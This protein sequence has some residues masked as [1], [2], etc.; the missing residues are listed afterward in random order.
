MNAVVMQDLV[1]LAAQSAVRLKE[2]QQTLTVA[3]SSAGGLISAALLAV[4]GAS[5]YYLGGTVV[6]TYAARTILLGL[7]QEAIA[8]MRSATEPYTLA[9]ARTARERLHSTWGLAET[10]ATGPRATGMVMPLATLVWPSAVPSTA[11]GRWKPAVQTESAICSRSRV[12]PSR[13]CWSVWNSP[14][15]GQES[16]RGAA[17][18]TNP[19]RRLA[20]WF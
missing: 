3:E 14:A 18:H 17:N 11:R 5:A 10:G 16:E 6:Y 9:L 19:A 4:P 7:E 1:S 20:T 8:G 2:R 12:R 13:C 15:I